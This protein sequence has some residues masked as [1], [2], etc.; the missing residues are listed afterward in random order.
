MNEIWIIIKNNKELL[1][2]NVLLL[3]FYCLFYIKKKSSLQKYY[4]DKENNYQILL[5][6]KKGLSLEILFQLCFFYFSF[7]AFFSVLEGISDQYPIILSEPL[8]FIIL[9]LCL[10]FWVLTPINISNLFY[11]EVIR[12]I[13]NTCKTCKKK[14]IKAGQE[15]QSHGQ[16]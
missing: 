2:T 9:Y 16:G 11:E 15:T 6:L 1:M 14:E 10:G 7:R 13:N 5:S 12:E 3:L 4:E 8:F